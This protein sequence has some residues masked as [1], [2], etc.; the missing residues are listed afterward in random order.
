MYLFTFDQ[1]VKLKISHPRFLTVAKRETL[2]M[3]FPACVEKRSSVQSDMQGDPNKVSH[4]GFLFPE[5]SLVHS[6]SSKN[7]FSY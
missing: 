7:A 3:E 1:N 5:V 4:N 6:I 2:D